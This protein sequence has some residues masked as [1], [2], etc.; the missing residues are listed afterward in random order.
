RPTG[1]PEEDTRDHIYQLKQGHKK[2][3]EFA[4]ETIVAENELLEKAVR[5]K[6]AD[7]LE[8]KKEV[9]TSYQEISNELAVLNNG[10]IA[11]L[12]KDIKAAIKKQSI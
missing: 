9:D 5:Q 11:R 2:C 12:G 8:L 3:L 7:I 10:N 6:H 1:N 4:L